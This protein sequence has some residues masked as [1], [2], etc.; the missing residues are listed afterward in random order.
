MSKLSE[1]SPEEV[2]ALL[3]KHAEKAKDHIDLNLRNGYNDRDDMRVIIW[4]QMSALLS[5]FSTLK[6]RDKA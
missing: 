2:M 3:D 6:P 1:F 5:E 4:N